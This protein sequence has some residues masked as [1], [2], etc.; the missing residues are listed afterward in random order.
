MPSLCAG[1]Q[2]AN[3]CQVV[4][5]VDEGVDAAV[6]NGGEVKDVTQDW[7]DLREKA[8]FLEAIYIYVYTYIYALTFTENFHSARSC[9]KN[10]KV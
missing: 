5:A 4:D 7:L 9:S 1:G 8:P 3:T 6:E 2:I 10:R